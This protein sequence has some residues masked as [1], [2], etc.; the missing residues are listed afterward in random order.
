MDDGKL[1]FKCGFM[2]IISNR[3]GSAD[4]VLIYDFDTYIPSGSAR[5]GGVIS[6]KNM[7]A[8]NLR[9][10]EADKIMLSRDGE[11]IEYDP[12][13]TLSRGQVVN[14]AKSPDGKI[15]D[16]RISLDTAVGEVTMVNRAE[17]EYIIG[18]ESYALSEYFKNSGRGLS[19][20]GGEITAYLD[21]N[22]NIADTS[23]SA[24]AM[25]Y[26]YLKSVDLSGDPFSDAVLLQVVTESGKAET[27]S[28][29]GSSILNGERFSLDKFAELR[30]QL[31]KFT[32][33]ADGSIGELQT[34]DDI[35][36]VPDQNRFARNYVSE[37][38]KYYDSLS[39]FASKYQLDPSTKVF[40]V[41]SD[42]SDITKY[43]V[44]GKA[45]LL[46]DTAYNVQIFDLSDE[47]KAGAVVIKSA[48]DSGSVYNYSPVCV[49]ESA[50][51][52]IAED[53]T[54]QLSLTAYVNGEK[55]EI[56]FGSEGAADRTGSWI[57]GYAER[58]TQNGEN[59]FSAGEVMQFS[60]RDG[61]CSAFRMLLTRDVIEQGAHYEKNL[62]D[63]GA[64]TAE[65]YY[66]ELYTAFG[67]VEHKFADKFLLS[68]GGENILRTVPAA[69][70]VYVY[71]KNSRRLYV[72]DAS[73]IE[74]GCE[75][76]TQIR[77][78]ATN[79]TVVMR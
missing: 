41:P 45:D 47:Y 48:D 75:A 68:A 43:R 55:R 67:T 74:Q 42:A 16:I 56:R 29:K 34:A 26:G 58:S 36:G 21:I 30:P 2:R 53:G 20:S 12:D 38:A 51:R 72:G 78:G 57:S 50:G 65:Q 46:S 31:V 59:P 4:Y 28:A 33:K 5:L 40:T 8:V 69:G 76:F 17:N 35:N 19:A 73:D 62:G 1:P 3:G 39:V 15:A 44:G 11:K 37:S 66:S 23:E 52:F 13:F 27:L 49:I 22:G 18:G 70:S 71:N 9:L 10:D 60:E 25:R 24:S 14:V 61:V 77:L 54:E 7:G 79:I 63:Y 32:V 64:L 6:D